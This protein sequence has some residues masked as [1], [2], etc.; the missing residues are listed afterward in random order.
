M[1]ITKKFVT[2]HSGLQQLQALVGII[3]KNS[4]EGDDIN[5]L[6]TDL[7][8]VVAAFA[9]LI[10]DNIDKDASNDDLS[11][12]C[13]QVWKTLDNTPELSNILVSIS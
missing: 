11:K 12:R 2:L 4:A 13:S 6:L 7:V 8:T 9:S 10:Y 5:D 1:I 3:Q